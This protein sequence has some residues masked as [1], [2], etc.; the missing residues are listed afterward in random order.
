[1]VRDSTGKKKVTVGDRK[2]GSR[3]AGTRTRS[4][5]NRQHHSNSS[6][7]GPGARPVA[8]PQHPNSRTDHAEHFPAPAITKALRY[9][10]SPTDWAMEVLSWTPDSWQRLVL[11]HGITWGQ[12]NGKRLA[13]CAGRQTGK[14][15]TCA[16]Y[17]LW[18][19]LHHPATT[20]L[21]ISAQERAAKEFL[22]RVTGFLHRIHEESHVTREETKL[23]V[24]LQNGSR[25]VSLP[26]T[27]A[28]PRGFTCH[29][30]IEDE[31]ARVD[32]DVHAAARPTT[33]ATGGK[34]ILLSTPFGQRGHFWQIYTDQQGLGGGWDRVSIRSDQCPRISPEYLAMEKASNPDYVFR[35]EYLC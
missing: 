29:L 28:A 15:E 12:G 8:Y 26:S 20:T 1:M 34:I 30:L 18:F 11:E 19:A 4:T 14:T 23:T 22:Q 10:L 35:S 31:S 17:A 2:K 27:E 16:V 24:T 25:V 9:A 3:K 32:D 7:K 6:R 5:K 13:I 21:I 33:A